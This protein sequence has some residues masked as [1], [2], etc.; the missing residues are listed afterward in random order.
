MVFDVNSNYL[1][2]YGKT[3]VFIIK[4]LS[5]D[6]VVKFDHSCTIS[7]KYERIINVKL[8]PTN[9]SLFKCYAS[10]KIKGQKNVAFVEI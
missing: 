6:R 3:Q 9:E 1:A 4:L 7:S 5:L 2:C 10:C 8:V